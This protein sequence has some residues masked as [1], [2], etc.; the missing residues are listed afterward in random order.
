MSR[1][2]KKEKTAGIEQHKQALR[3]KKMKKKEKKKATISANYRKN[4]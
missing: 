3:E 2:S 1:R 4:K